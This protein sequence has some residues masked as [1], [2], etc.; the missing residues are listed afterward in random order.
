MRIA[1]RFNVGCQPRALVSPEGTADSLPEVPFVGHTAIQPSLR[2]LCNPKPRLPTLKRWAIL[3]CP[4]G[5][6][7]GASRLF[8]LNVVVAELQI[9][10]QIT[11]NSFEPTF[12]SSTP[13][14]NF[15]CLLTAAWLR[16]FDD[17]RRTQTQS[18]GA[19]VPAIQSQG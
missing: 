11:R 19:P 2:D 6:D 15:V 12:I 8:V 3:A 14:P 10:R 13:E 17:E 1:Q 7:F 4:V 16:L 9:L 18:G 5:T